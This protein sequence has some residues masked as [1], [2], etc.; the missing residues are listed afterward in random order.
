[1]P[2]AFFGLAAA[3]AAPFL[4]VLASLIGHQQADPDLWGRLSVPALAYARGALPRAD[5]FSFTAAGAP[6]LDHEWAS[7][8]L[9]DGALRLGGE[10]AL[11]GLAYAALLAAIAGVVVLHRVVYR[12][13]VYYALVGL[14]AT[15]GVYELG[16]LSTVRCQVLTFVLWLSYLGVLEAVRVG[17]ARPRALCV[18]VP[19]AILWMNVHGGFVL[20]PAAVASYALDAARARGWRASVPHG[21]GLCG[22]AGCTGLA[23]PYGLEFPRFVVHALLLDR[24]H[25]SEWVP[26]GFGPGEP[27]EPQM[28][29]VLALGSC[30]LA[31]ARGRRADGGGL[32]LAPIV[33]TLVAT[34]MAVRALRFQ[35]LLAFTVCAYL[36]VLLPA[37]SIAFVWANES[38]RRVLRAAAAAGAVVVVLLGAGMVAA[39][40]PDRSPWVSPVSTG[41]PVAAIRYLRAS[42]YRGNLLNPFTPGELL[43]FALYPRFRVSMDGRYEEVYS[44][45]EFLAQHHLLVERALARTLPDWAR[46]RGVDFILLPT[47]SPDA[48]A[49]LRAHPG[50][51]KLHGDESYVLFGRLELVGERPFVLAAASARARYSIADFVRP[52]DL[53][54]FAAPTVGSAR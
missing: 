30:A 8:F 38:R 20:G 51:R 5:P 9:F 21:A 24:A 10:A 27:L 31:I 25:I 48:L 39:H 15:G 11:L 50:W 45:D 43:Y 41:Y 2:R 40:A 6:W 44:Q 17:R 4:L 14:V 34:L 35:T 13:S 3:I 18:L 52:E 19:L 33:L 26:L 53:A 42:P 36:P 22:L 29:V 12:A 1:M 54:R 49:V 28:L 23:T 47:D 16:Y 46:R 7:G 32:P 37:D